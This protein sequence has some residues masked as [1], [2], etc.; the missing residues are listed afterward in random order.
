MCAEGGRIAGR[1]LSGCAQSLPFSYLNDTFSLVR[2]SS[3]LPSLSCTSCAVTS[4]MRRSQSNSAARST[5]VRAAFSQRLAARADELDDFVDAVGGHA[6]PPGFDTGMVGRR[7]QYLASRKR[8]RQHIR[9]K[10]ALA[11]G[12]RERHSVPSWT[13]K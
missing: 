12:R 10:T 6:L 5:A 13:R 1:R 3:I 9:D 8:T 4:A 11:S 7:R 2:N